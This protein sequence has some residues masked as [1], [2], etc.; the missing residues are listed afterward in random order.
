MKGVKVV[1]RKIPL[2]VGKEE[3]RHFERPGVGPEGRSGQLANNPEEGREQKGNPKPRTLAETG[4]SR[5]KR[6]HTLDSPVRR[7]QDEEAKRDSPEG[8]LKSS[9]DAP[10]KKSWGGRK[11]GKN[12]PTGQRQER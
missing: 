4:P 5:P 8:R 11:S 10:R 2:Q 12:R 1:L 3:R 7:G 9:K 6:M